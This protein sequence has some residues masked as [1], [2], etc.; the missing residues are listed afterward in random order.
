MNLKCPHQPQDVPFK[1][2]DITHASIKTSTLNAFK[3]QLFLNVFAQ[4]LGGF[5][6]E[7]EEDVLTVVVR[8][9]NVRPLYLHTPSL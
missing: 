5:S 4:C 8:T 2:Q 1:A 7:E 3:A 9:R 6:R